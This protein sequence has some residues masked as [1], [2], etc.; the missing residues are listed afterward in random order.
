MNRI[1]KIIDYITGFFRSV[2]PESQGNIT[3][4]RIFDMLQEENIR[5][6]VL[7]DANYKTISV[8]DMKKFLKYNFSKTKKYAAEKYDCD[9]FASVLYGQA[10]YFLGGFA[11][12]MVHV[13]VSSGGAHA[14]NLMIYDN[15][16]YYVEPQNGRVFPF[17]SAP[18]Y[19][20]Y[21]VII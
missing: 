18:E 8:D 3:G 17:D 14:L 5:F 21:F 10:S 1:Q 20:P 13:R 4:S 11:I 6:N 16:L 7:V 12:G 2:K 9:N 19:E 15:K